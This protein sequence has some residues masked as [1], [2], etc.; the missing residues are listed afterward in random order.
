MSNLVLRGFIFFSLVVSF[1]T[2]GDEKDLDGSLLVKEHC[3]Q[4]HG[5]DGNGGPDK[6][7]KAPK[8]AGFS[9]LL[10]YDSLI[11]FK[12]EDRK[13]IEIKNKNGQLTNMKKISKLRSEDEIV[14]ISLYLGK[15]TFKAEPQEHDKQLAIIGKQLH[16]DLCNDCHTDLG[17]SS[18][19]DAPI[20]S[21]QKKGYLLD[22]FEKITNF[23]RNISRKMRRKFKKLTPQDKKAMIE[24]YASAQSNKDKERK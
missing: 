6:R 9:A 7:I 17:T 21:G 19:D 14:A 15:Q 8:I 2:H 16:Q 23:E 4:C 3:A 10:I 1:I 24:F 11:Q 12:D 18:A 13:A 5:A 20:L 22:Q